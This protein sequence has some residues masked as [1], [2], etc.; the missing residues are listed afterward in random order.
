MELHKGSKVY[1]KELLEARQYLYQ[2]LS[3]QNGRAVSVSIFADLLEIEEER[4][5]NAVEG[6]LGI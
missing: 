5:R 4:W 2:K 1:P 6:Y 3:E